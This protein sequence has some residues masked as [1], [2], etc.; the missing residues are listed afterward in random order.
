MNDTKFIK[1]YLVVTVVVLPMRSTL[2]V[3]S[4]QLLREVNL[5]NHFPQ[6][7]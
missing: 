6:F 4:S 7:A 5:E 1:A 3:N 2:Q